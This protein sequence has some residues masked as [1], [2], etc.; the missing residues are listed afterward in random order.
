MPSADRASSRPY[1]AGGAGTVTP[2]GFNDV[3][4]P[5]NF[6]QIACGKPDEQCS[7]ETL[8]ECPERLGRFPVHPERDFKVR[9]LQRAQNGADFLGNRVAQCGPRCGVEAGL[10]HRRRPIDSI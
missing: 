9:A 10:S 8:P 2:V 4:E 6:D 5:S 1:P 7:N 3:L